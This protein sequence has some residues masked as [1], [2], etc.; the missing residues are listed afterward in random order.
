TGPQL[1]PHAAD[2]SGCQDLKA[3]PLTAPQ[4]GAAFRV[5][6]PCGGGF[7]ISPGRIATEGTMADFAKNIS[8]FQQIDR[9]VVDKTGLSGTFDLTVDYAPQLPG[10]Q[11]GADATGD[12]SLP[13]TIFTALQE[14]LGLKLVPETGPVDVLVIDHVEEPSAN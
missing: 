8:W 6:I 9:F 14:Q 2:N 12:S 7:L 13:S 4:P 1:V 10:G 3:K 5:P 11:P